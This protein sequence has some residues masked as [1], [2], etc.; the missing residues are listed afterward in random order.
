M[1]GI[2]EFDI[3]SGSGVGHGTP[4]FDALSERSNYR[5]DSQS[6][7]SEPPSWASVALRRRL[8]Q[9]CLV[10]YSDLVRY[11]FPHSVKRSDVTRWKQVY[12]TPL[13][14]TS[15][16][17]TQWRHSVKTRLYKTP[18]PYFIVLASS[19]KTNEVKVIEFHRYTWIMRS[20][21]LLLFHMMELNRLCHWRSIKTTL[22]QRLAF[23]HCSD[24]GLD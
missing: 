2:L 1:K 9:N 19:V 11:G 8:R 10:R 21:R 12:I 3:V 7:V 4:N 14:H 20:W 13:P 17:E 5:R 6:T 23:K 22:G 15:F 18:H 16:Y 24:I